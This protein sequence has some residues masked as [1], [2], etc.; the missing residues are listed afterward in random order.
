MCHSYTSIENN[1]WGISGAI[2]PRRDRLLKEER[3]ELGFTSLS[4]A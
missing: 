3:K 1:N 4:T 2:P